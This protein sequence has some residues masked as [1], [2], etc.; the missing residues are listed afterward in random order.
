[1][2]H[3]QQ[4]YH[5]ASKHLATNADVCALTIAVCLLGHQSAAILLY[6]TALN[7]QL[8]MTVRLDKAVSIHWKSHYAFQVAAGDPA[9]IGIPW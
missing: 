8:I 1:M 4:C 6:R 3:V 5:L 7:Q 2:V 9:Q